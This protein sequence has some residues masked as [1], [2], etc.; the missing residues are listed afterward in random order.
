M[1][2]VKTARVADWPTPSNKKKVQSFVDF[3]NFYHQ[4][5][6]GFLHH[7]CALFLTMK[8][9]RSIWGEPQ[10]DPS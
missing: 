1:D 4:F 9:V 8:D 3:V 10:E 5:I 2:P 6:P 7:T